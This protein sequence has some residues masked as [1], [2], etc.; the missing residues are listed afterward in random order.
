MT[1]KGWVIVYPVLT[2][3]TKGTLKSRSVAE[4]KK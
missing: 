3:R 2:I 1:F 4:H